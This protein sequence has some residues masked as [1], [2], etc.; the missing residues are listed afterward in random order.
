MLLKNVAGQGIFLFSV[1]TTTTP[2]SPKTGD[3]ANVTGSHSL[4][5]V[6]TAGFGTAHPTEMGMGVYWQP[7]S[8]A[9]TN[10][11][12]YAYTWASSTTGIVIHPIIGFTSGVNL[13][14]VAFGGAGGLVDFADLPTNFAS[15]SIDSSGHITL[16]PT[17]LDQVVD[18]SYTARQAL[19][20]SACALLG[21]ISGLPTSPGT[22]KDLDGTTTRAVI[23][24][25]SSNNR[26][27]VTITP[28]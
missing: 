17:G 11:N 10:G 13:P 19:F 28:P 14:A 23:S 16:S 4:D 5:G 21:K 9:E 12:A 26:T 24:F 3:S 8:Q 18:G 27:A 22:I 1:D 20:L 2:Y 15:L 25:D 6:Y 7:L